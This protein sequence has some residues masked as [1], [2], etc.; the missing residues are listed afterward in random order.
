MQSGADGY[1]IMKSSDLLAWTP[2]LKY[3]EM[4]APVA[5]ADGT[6]QKQTCDQE[7]WCR[8]CSQLEAAESGPPGV[9][10]AAGRHGRLGRQGLL[11]EQRGAGAGGVRWSCGVGALLLL[12]RRR[13]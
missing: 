2:V 6:V 8:L 3:Q 5:H 13:R 12:R 11:Q 4:K 1:G 10:P 9:Q 7:M